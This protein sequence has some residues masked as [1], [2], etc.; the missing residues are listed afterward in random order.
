MQ[1]KKLDIDIIFS[2]KIDPKQIR[3]IKVREKGMGV[4]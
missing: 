1:K 3:E 4:K 2:A